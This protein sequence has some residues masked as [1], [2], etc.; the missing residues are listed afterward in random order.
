M[1]ILI[2]DDEPLAR[3]RLRALLN[4]IGGHEVL[5]IEAANGREVL[6]M[7]KAYKP[8]IVTM[9]IGMPSINGM[10]AAKKLST[11]PHPPIII[12]TTAY[13]EYALDAFEQQAVDYLL[14]P[15]RRE[16]LEQALDRAKAWHKKPQVEK[17]LNNTD[18]S[19]RA[20][21]H[22]SINMHGEVRLIP[23][24]KAYYFRAEQKYVTMAWSG[25][26]V[27]LDESLKNL[28]EEFSGQFLRIHRNAL[29]ALVHVAGWKK[30]DNGQHY[31]TFTG[32]DEQLE[33]S[34]RHLQNVKHTIR[35]MCGA[36]RN[37]KT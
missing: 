5:E 28:E 29:V 7:S 18:H 3:R 14:K 20:R 36:R 12:F 32:I 16:R 26:E 1:R 31:I 21:T 4:E 27:L 25:G 35:D 13:S 22:I 24:E 11:Y 30:D 6:E 2:A 9:D 17:D 19:K 10:D 33:I 34:R 37:A 8:D 15:I 23:V